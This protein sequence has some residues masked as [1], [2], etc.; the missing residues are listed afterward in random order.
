MKRQFWWLL[1]QTAYKVSIA[2]LKNK[3]SFNVVFVVWER[4]I[5]KYDSLFKLMYKDKCFNPMILVC[6]LVGL[7]NKQM[8]DKVKETYS[9][10][11]SKGYNTICACNETADLIVNIDD[12]SPDVIFYPTP[13]PYQIPK[14]YNQ[15]TRLKYLKCYV[16]YAYVNVIYS[17]S[18]ASAVQGLM[19]L[20]FVE[21]ESNKYLALSYS[22]SEFKNARVVGYP[23]YDEYQATKGDASMWKS[24]DPKFKRIIWVPHHSIEGHNG[25]L[26]FSTFLENAEKILEFAENNKDKYQFAFKP[27]PLLLQA[28]YN[29]PKWGKEKADA[30]YKSWEEGENTVLQTGTYMELFKSSD[31][32][33]HDCGSFIIEYLYTQKPVMYLGNNRKEQSNVVGKKAYA[34]HYHGTTIEDINAFLDDVV[35]NGNDDLKT[36]RKQFYNEVLLPPNGCSVAE[37]IINEIKKELHK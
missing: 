37:N 18:I 22:K 17:W 19:W 26:S 32:M 14:Q 6:P 25:L 11:I 23:I 36:T 16:N 3:Q 15:Y 28:L 33:I 5:W 7:E 27:H 9:Y 1:Q 24:A 34:C 10:F 8:L 13:Y 12:L 2:K 20:Y 35:Q 31:A 29:H 21:C 4:S 30:Y